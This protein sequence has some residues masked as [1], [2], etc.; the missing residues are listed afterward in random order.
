MRTTDTFGVH[1]IARQM[2]SGNTYIY[3]RISVNRTRAELGIKQSISK[4]DWNE[5]KGIARPKND[6]LK[7]LN[8]YLEEVRGKLV[9]HY[10]QLRLG[11]LE[12]Y[13]QAS[14]PR[15]QGLYSLN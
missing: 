14:F 6:E 8:T 11:D 5:A 10:Q 9:W 1:F 12:I 15:K 2:P 4:S 7:Q 3:A 13:E